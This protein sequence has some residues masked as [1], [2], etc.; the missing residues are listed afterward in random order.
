MPDY[1]AY[2]L[3]IDG[4]RFVLVEGFL[5]NYPDDG[6]ALIAAKK[7]ID[8]HDIEVWDRGR[9]VARLDH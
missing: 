6:A 5:S 7:L 3:G 2:I 4:H 8:G 9:L 1:R